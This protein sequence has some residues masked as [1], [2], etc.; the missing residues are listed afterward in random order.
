MQM[1]DLMIY[2]VLIF[3]FP[4]GVL[5]GYRWRD[6]VSRKRRERFSSQRGKRPSA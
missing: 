5:V 4:L 1:F 2:A 3:A 6:R